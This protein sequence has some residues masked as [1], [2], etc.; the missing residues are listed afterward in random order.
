MNTVV[1]IVGGAAVLAAA[2]FLADR[3]LLWMEERGWIYWRKRKSLLSM[4]SDVLQE[5]TPG[6]RAQKH[7]LEQERVRKNVR[8]AE[9]PPFQVDL[10]AQVVR[11]RQPRGKP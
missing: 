10:D 3:A 9:E 6:A 7:A 5:V 4:G 11:I 8:P 1:L 2:L